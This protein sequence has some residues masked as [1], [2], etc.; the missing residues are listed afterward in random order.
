[1]LI[2]S[3]FRVQHNLKSSNITRF[4][5][6]RFLIRFFQFWR[7]YLQL[8]PNGISKIIFYRKCFGDSRIHINVSKINYRGT[9]LN[10]SKFLARQFFI[11]KFNVSWITWFLWK[12]PY[13]LTLQNITKI[14][15]FKIKKQ[16]TFL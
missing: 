9:R 5:N 11:D 10:A 4:E 2:M 15:V 6:L 1:M 12:Y 3:T 7:R 14:K 13:F 16:H 8:N